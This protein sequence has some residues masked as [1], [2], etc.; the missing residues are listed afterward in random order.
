MYLSYPHP[1][2]PPKKKKLHNLC[3]SFLLGITA[4]PRGIENN[5]YAKFGG[6]EGGGANKVH[7]GICASGVFSQETGSKFVPKNNPIVQ[8]DG[9][10]LRRISKWPIQTKSVSV[11]RR[12]QTFA[13]RVFTREWYLSIGWRTCSHWLNLLPWSFTEVLLR[14]DAAGM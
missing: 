13:F 3:F 1:H 10:S 14:P 7:Y 8:F 9:P 12:V 11:C 2:P 6:G 4:V 5:A